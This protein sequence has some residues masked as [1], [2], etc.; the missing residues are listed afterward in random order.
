MT[1]S[2]HILSFRWS[3]VVRCRV[4]DGEQEQVLPV[5]TTDAIETHPRRDH[6]HHTLDTHLISL[7]ELLENPIVHRL[8]PFVLVSESR[9]SESQCIITKSSKNS[10]MEG[11]WAGNVKTLL[12]YFRSISYTAATYAFNQQVDGIRATKD[13]IKVTAIKKT[14][15]G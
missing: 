3:S 15:E 6:V 10:I 7:L 4:V 11:E 5:H 13:G 2:S 14:I 1:F 12:I 8:E 9:R